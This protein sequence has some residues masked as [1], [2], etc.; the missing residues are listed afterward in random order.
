MQTLGHNPS[1][2]EL[3]I[4]I[5]QA[6]T[7]GSS[8]AG[9]CRR[10]PLSLRLLVQVDEDRS[11]EIDFKEFLVVFERQRAS[12][13]ADVD[14]NM[15]LEAFVA[16]GGQVGARGGLPPAVPR[17]C[18]PPPWPAGEGCTLLALAAAPPPP[19]PGAKRSCAQAD[20]GGQVP[21]DKLIQTLK[22][23]ARTER[24]GSAGG[25]WTRRPRCRRTLSC[26]S[27]WTRCCGRWTRTSQ[28]PSTTMSSGSCWHD[29]CQLGL[30]ATGGCFQGTP[31]GGRQ[32]D[33]LALAAPI[34]VQE[35]V[36]WA[37]DPRKGATSDCQACSHSSCSNWPRSCLCA[38]RPGALWPVSPCAG[39]AGCQQLGKAPAARAGARQALQQRSPGL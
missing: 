29:D 34:C 7:L 37:P 27:T 39:A 19:P 30:P 5:S 28:P 32:C 21:M 17:C 31:A 12:K 1:D 24:R 4:L 18:P 8:P 23:R 38:W 3:F 14:D 25:S 20:K 2:E 36:D 35:P 15:T 33:G 11:G 10:A 6:R 16:M 22:A 13:V 26:S 9:A